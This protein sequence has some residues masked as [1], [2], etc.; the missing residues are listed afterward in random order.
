MQTKFI[1]VTNGCKNYG[2]F[3]LMRFDTEWEYRSA[4]PGCGGNPLLKS[5]GWNPN[6]IWVLDLQTCEG[7]AFC[8]GGCSKADLEKHRVWVCPLF[9][10]FLEWLYAELA[11]K[12]FDDLPAYIDLP[13]AP[14]LM[15]GYRRQGKAHAA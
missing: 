8:P 9:E 7:A 5:I 13:D 12:L 1:E 15:S 2:K 14:F 11:T 3:L 6:Q 10:P 4:A